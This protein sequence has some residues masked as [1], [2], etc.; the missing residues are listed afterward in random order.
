MFWAQEQR[1]K[2]DRRWRVMGRQEWQE[3]DTPTLV[4]QGTL[5]RVKISGVGESGSVPVEVAFQ[6]RLEKPR[7]VGT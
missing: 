5:K 7:T 4:A 6:L 3:T 2:T 1:A